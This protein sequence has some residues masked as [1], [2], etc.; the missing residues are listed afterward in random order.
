MNRQHAT[1]IVGAVLFLV[2]AMGIGRFSL[3]P[4]LPF[5]RE[6]E[7]L[8]VEKGGWLASANYIG[9]F[10]GALWA[11][12]IVKNQ[13]K[14]L[15]MNAWICVISI[16]GMGI[17]HNFYVWLVLR[18]ING[19]TGGLIFVLTSSMLLDYLAR[20]Y[21][22]KWSGY[23]FSGIGV[24]IA[25]SGILVPYLQKFFAWQGAFIGLSILSAVFVL[26]NHFLW[27]K[28]EDPAYEK[29]KGTTQKFWTGFMPWITIAYGLEGLGYIITGTF[30]VDMIHEMP[31]LQNYAS[32]S[33]VIVGIGAIPSAPIWSLLMSKYKPMVI[34]TSAYIL[35]IIGII[36]PVISTTIIGVMV[37]ALLF[38]VT[39][40][41]IVVLTTS[42]CRELFPTKSAS[43]VSTLTTYYAVGQIIGPLIAGKLAT[44]FGGYNSALIFAGSVV[45][46][47]LCLLLFGK[48]Y[49]QIKLNTK[50][51]TAKVI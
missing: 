31:S 14:G 13:K 42:Y 38:G 26:T 6:A 9:Y 33:W 34:I 24:G 22:T 12:F 28:L 19:I 48:K 8:S 37:S 32:Y 35:Q 36:L 7:G 49:S 51:S 5:L 21:L 3:T 17:V 45:A 46:S 50:T 10:I 20:H 47:A 27:Q 40:V 41:G 30:L 15:Y 43:V 25:L 29:I 23:V 39:F 2:V 4:I 11:G 1:I 18:L 16:L 44:Y